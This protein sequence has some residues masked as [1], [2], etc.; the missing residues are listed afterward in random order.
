MHCFPVALSA[1]PDLAFVFFLL[2]SSAAACWLCS[3]CH[4]NNSWS[5]L[6][7]QQTLENCEVDLFA[8]V[9]NA[10]AGTGDGAPATV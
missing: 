2:H 7:T 5:K 4:V 10:N 9:M 8:V 6:I 1:V 3:R